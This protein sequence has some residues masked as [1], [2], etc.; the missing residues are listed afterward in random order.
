M[1]AGQNALEVAVTNEWTNRIAGDRIVPAAERVLA[2]S[3]GGGF[4]GGAPLPTSGLVG[5]VRI[6]RES[7]LQPAEGEP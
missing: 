4:A 5:P 7:E 2:S 6:L 1:H 3:G